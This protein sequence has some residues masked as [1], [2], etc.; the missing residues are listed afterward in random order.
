MKGKLAMKESSSNLA[1]SPEAL[2]QIQANM[3]LLSHLQQT[4][5]G[6]LNQ[7]LQNHMPFAAF[8]GAPPLSFPAV[9]IRRPTFLLYTDRDEEIL[10]DY[11][12]MIRK[13]I[14]VFEAGM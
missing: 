4:Q 5:S 2:N 12:C 14:E 6:L 8:A 11:Q 10:T 7:P 1:Q 13:Q 3:L 9:S